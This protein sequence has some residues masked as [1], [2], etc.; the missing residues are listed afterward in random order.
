[1]NTGGGL[2]LDST[3]ELLKQAKG[4]DRDAVDRL[5]ARYLP[6]LKRWATGRIPR[7]ARGMLDTDDIV[8]DTLLQTVKQIE[9]F[10][11]RREGALQAYLRAALRNR[12]HDELRRVHAK[13][14]ATTP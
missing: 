12:L 6:M 10:D 5:C 1:M 13:P 4:G 7:G 14:T 3:A 9:R 8:Q 11:Y 2:P